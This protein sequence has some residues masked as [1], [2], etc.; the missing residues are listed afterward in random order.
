M[1]VDFPDDFMPPQVSLD[2]VPLVKVWGARFFVEQ[3]RELWRIRVPAGLPERLAFV[4][5]IDAIIGEIISARDALERSL[6]DAVR[7]S[8]LQSWEQEIRQHIISAQEN[9]NW[10]ARILA[11]RNE[12]LH[13]NYLP[14]QIRIGGRYPVDMRLQRYTNGIV[15]DTDLPEDLSLVCDR[16]EELISLSRQAVATAIQ[17]RNSRNDAQSTTDGFGVFGDGRGSQS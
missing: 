17:E 15:S 16:M 14:E 5:L 12:G 2:D 1:S 13:G 4:S 9:D 8:N 7:A 3:L 10:L 6:G 11:L